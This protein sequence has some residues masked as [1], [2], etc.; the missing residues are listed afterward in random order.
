MRTTLCS[1]Q[2]TLVVPAGILMA[3]GTL[4]HLQLGPALPS[5][6]P[7]LPEGVGR[8]HCHCELKLL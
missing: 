6:L 4:G 1:P 8:S 2:L 7:I 5:K 3:G